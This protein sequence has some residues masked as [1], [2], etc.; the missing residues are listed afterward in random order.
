MSHFA[1][2]IA[3]NFADDLATVSVLW[4]RD[5][6]RFLRQPSRLVGALMQPLVFW[7]VIG[8]GL[9]STFRFGAEPGVG[10]MQYFFPGIVVMM[11]LFASIFGTITVIEDRHAGFLQ[12]VL[13][14]PGSRTAVVIGKSL[15]VSSVGLLQATA[16]LLLA[17]VGGFGFAQI[18]WL[19]L[20]SFLVVGA[21]GLSSFGFALAWLTDSSQAYHAVMSILL[22]PMWILSGAM[23]PPSDD[24]PVLQTLMRY[25]PMSYM[26][27]GVRRALHASDI[28]GA[29]WTTLSGSLA[30]D[31]IWVL[32]FAAFSVAAATILI[33]RRR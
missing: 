24:H 5:L 17:P 19:I 8:G 4:Q 22:L 13:V 27:S 26:V 14:A 33:H 23:F 11:V 31:F 21:V 15:G 25:N 28:N 6:L 29:S 12:A 2:K 16:F 20:A 7:F 1:Q 32:V 30:V 9:A 3:H 18:D 10:Y